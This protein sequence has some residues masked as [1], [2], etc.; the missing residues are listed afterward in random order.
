MTQLSSEAQRAF[1]S[2]LE[3]VRLSLRGT[4]VDALEVERDVREHIEE[5]LASHT[6]PVSR[7]ELA[8]V[9]ERLG[10]PSQWVPED[11]VS[12]W[13][14][15][16]R[17]WQV[18]PEDWRLS[19]VCFGLTALGLVTAVLGGV[20]LWIP[21]YFLGRAAHALAAE[22]GEPLGPRKWLIYPVLLAVA[23]PL[24][25][26]LLCGPLLPLIIAGVDQGWFEALGVS[27]RVAT[28]TEALKVA[29]LVGGA[30][31]LWWIV[32]ALVS[33]RAVRLLRAILAPLAD[34]LQQRHAW[35]L[36]LAGAV[37]GLAATAIVFL[38]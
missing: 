28:T 5:A 10:S 4:S 25:A 31:G 11:E 2:Y 8:T 14:R 9:L 34:S 6:T 15:F 29:A 3:R 16:V 36:V 17:R 26:M 35:W 32:L 37:V 18:G 19:Y 13:R 20:L 1:E 23:L 27:S 12:L 22:R 33:R 7:D 30:I 24:A 21:A 38:V